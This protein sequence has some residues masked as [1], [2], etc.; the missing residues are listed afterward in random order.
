VFDSLV[1]E[2]IKVY[3]FETIR[4]SFISVELVMLISLRILARDVVVDDLSE[5]PSILESISNSIFKNFLTNFSEK[6]K[7]KKK[8]FFF[9]SNNYLHDLLFY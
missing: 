3:V 1:K 5:P 8:K 6:K 2:C 9:I 4:S 7:K